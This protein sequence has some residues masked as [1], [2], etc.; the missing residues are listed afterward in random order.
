[1]PL[2]RIQRVDHAGS[3]LGQIITYHNFQEN[4]HFP[5]TWGLLVIRCSLRHSKVHEIIH[6]I[7]QC[8][9]EYLTMC[10]MD[11]VPSVTCNLS[12]QLSCFLWFFKELNKEKAE[13]GV[14]VCDR[15][16]WLFTWSFLPPSP[17]FSL[18]SLSIFLAP[19]SRFRVPLQLLARAPWALL[20]LVLLAVTWPLGPLDRLICYLSWRDD[21]WPHTSQP[22]S[23]FTLFH[24]VSTNRPWKIKVKHFPHQQL[25][26]E[27]RNGSAP[28]TPSSS[29]HRRKKML[30]TVISQKY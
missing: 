21:R 13:V 1:M 23:P 30:H 27:D 14:N 25:Y 26:Q 19:H 29:C 11:T 28:I 20:L 15:S 10:D 24:G 17:H 8:W 7:N 22:Q 4:I 12:I 5:K 9:Q 3:Q 18:P 16:Y 2:E 6:S